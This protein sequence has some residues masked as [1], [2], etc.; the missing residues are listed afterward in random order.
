MSALKHYQAVQEGIIK[1][2]L[3][4]QELKHHPTEYYPEKVRKLVNKY[5]T[6]VREIIRQGALYLDA[7]EDWDLG[8]DVI[9]IVE[10]Y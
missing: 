8:Q 4:R 6:I 5:I 10:S 3:I 9:Q 2:R 1:A 7:N